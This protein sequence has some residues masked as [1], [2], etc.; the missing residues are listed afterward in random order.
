MGSTAHPHEIG[1]PQ[2]VPTLEAESSVASRRRRRSNAAIA[3]ASAAI[4]ASG[5]RNRDRDDQATSDGAEQVSGVAHGI[6]RC[7]ATV[8][9]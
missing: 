8:G 5:A 4:A 1:V 2:L 7:P 9:L 3:I 6:A